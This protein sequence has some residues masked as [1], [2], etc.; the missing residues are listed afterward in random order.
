LSKP[1]PAFF[2]SEG[3][4]RFGDEH[5]DEYLLTVVY[6]MDLA[7]ETYDDIAISRAPLRPGDLLAPTQW[8]GRLQISPGPGTLARSMLMS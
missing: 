8:S 4:R 1:L 2:L 7:A 6:G 3:E 5:A